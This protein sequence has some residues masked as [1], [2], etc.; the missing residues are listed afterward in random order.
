MTLSTL[1][2]DAKERLALQPE[3]MNDH[4][5][6]LDNPVKEWRFDGGSFVDDSGRLTF[7]PYVSKT[8]GAAYP[9]GKVERELEEIVETCDDYIALAAGRQLPNR[10]RPM[11]SE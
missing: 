9:G 2:T 4:L 10:A 8:T 7:K 5:L 3:R 1:P 11:A 6:A